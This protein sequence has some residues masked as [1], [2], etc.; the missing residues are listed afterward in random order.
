MSHGRHV[1]TDSVEY[2]DSSVDRVTHNGQHTGHESITHGNFCRRI[3][4]QYYKHVMQQG[5]DTAQTEPD[6]PETDPDINQHTDNSHC[7]GNHCVGLHLVADDRAD[8]LG[9]DH[10]LIHAEVVH[11]HLIQLFSLLH[12]QGTGLKDDLIGILHCLYLYRA[13][14][15]LFNERGHI[16]IGFLQCHSLGECHRGSRAAFKFQTVIQGIPGGYLVHA[17][18]HKACNDHPKG[19]AK[20]KPFFGKDGQRLMLLTNTVELLALQSQGVESIQQ[21]PGHHQG[22]EHGKHYTQRQCLRKAFHRTGSQQKQYAGGDQ[23]GNITVDDGGKRFVKADLDGIAHSL[24]RSQ[25]FADTRKNDHICVHCHTDGQDNARH[26][27]QGQCH[28]KAV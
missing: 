3:E 23:S 10:I 21:I 7:H 1:F 6:V 28:V 2:D 25:F 17:H 18:D 11:E 19:D 26:A 8:S 15:D 13:A 24:A 4:R 20:E 14:R 16:R 9:S 12:I 5:Y 27:G 22:S